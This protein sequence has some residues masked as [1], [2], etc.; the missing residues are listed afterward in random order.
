MVKNPP[1]NAGGAREL[2]SVPGVGRFPGGGR[3]N[4]LHY[5]CLENPMD[6]G[7]RELQSIGSQRVGH[8]WRDLAQHT[9]ICIVYDLK[10]F[11]VNEERRIMQLIWDYATNL[12]DC[13]C[14]REGG[15]GERTCFSKKWDLRDSS[16]GWK[17][18]NVSV[19][20]VLRN[21]WDG[22]KNIRK[23]CGF[24]Y[25]NFINFFIPVLSRFNYLNIIEH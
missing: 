11:L 9:R 15:K 18:R 21:K 3:G 4:P 12:G 2:G 22:I 25:Q 10:V 1:A 17:W 16:S 5:S 24:M 20:W 8:D 6:R 14:I 23:P 13:D 7:H 19:S